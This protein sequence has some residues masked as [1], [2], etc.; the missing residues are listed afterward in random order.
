MITNVLEYLSIAAVAFGMLYF[1]MAAGFIAWERFRTRSRVNVP[2]RRPPVSVLKPLKG[3]DD[4]LENNLRSFFELDYPSYE[5]LFGVDEADDPAIAVVQRLRR[6]YPQIPVRLVVDSQRVGLNPKINNLHN[7]FPFARYD[8]LVISDS[9]VRVR[10]EYLTDLLSHMQSDEVGM[11]TS[12]IRGV[13]AKSLGAVLENLHLNTYIADS[14]YAVGNLFGV[15]VTIGKSMLIRRETLDAVGGFRAFAE[16]LLED[17]LLGR[18]IAQRGMRIVT[19]CSPVENVNVTWSIDK[20]L[21]R[22]LR[23]ATMRRRLHA[24]HYTAELLSNPTAIA[25]VN[26]IVQR[27]PMSLA[28]LTGVAA[29]RIVLDMITGL[30]MESES[31]WSHYLMV[32]LKDL[33]MA[34]VWLVPFFSNTVTWRGNEFRVLK[35]TRLESVGR[36]V[37]EPDLTIG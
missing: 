26:L 3:L 17:G 16:Y 21:S 29:G 11:V 19:T 10:R 18:A 6:A 28:L 7:M 35:Y 34:G 24:G 33:V 22:H 15:P 20:F 13:G 27:D 32:P 9:N 36:E 5:L 25:L 37:A 30:L 31:R 14:V 8:Y 1:A 12:H 23:W 2:V 4:Q